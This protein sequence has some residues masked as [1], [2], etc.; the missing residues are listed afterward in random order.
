MKRAAPVFLGAAML[1]LAGCEA[2]PLEQFIHLT[3]SGNVPLEVDTVP[4]DTNGD[5]KIEGF[6]AEEIEA[7]VAVDRDLEAAEPEA[8]LVR[9]TE[10]EVRYTLL[11]DAGQIPDYING[12]A[13]FLRGGETGTWPLRAVSFVQ[14]EWAQDR[15]G[16]QD[17]NATATLFL[18][19]HDD[20]DE[21]LTFE[22]SAD[23]D[24]IFADFVEP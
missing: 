13:M 16:S 6:H 12:A 11:D 18:R 20:A 14:K 23:F 10:Y 2:R 5:G 4:N 15:Y 19:G 8:P 22:V 7:Q 17:L 3:F 24:I 21:A 9:V 1:L